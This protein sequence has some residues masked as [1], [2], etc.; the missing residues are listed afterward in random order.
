MG[1]F[2]LGITMLI[3]KALGMIYRIPLT[4]ILGGTG[5]GYYSSA[6]TVFMPLYAIAA[7]G[8][9]SA[10]SMV[11]AESYAFERYKNIRRIK[12]VSLIGFSFISLL[13]SLLM[14]FLSY[15]ISKY[16]SG[17][18]KAYLC[19]IAIAPSQY[20]EAITRVLGI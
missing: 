6:Y 1:S 13:A 4:N 2:I 15:P 16:I 12:H 7:S 11:V 8:I 3:T 17:D 14:I 5:M 18:S 20:T 10:M 19:V 9:P